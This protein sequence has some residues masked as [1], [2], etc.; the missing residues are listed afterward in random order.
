MIFKKEKTVADHLWSG[1]SLWTITLC[2]T[3]V[4]DNTELEQGCRTVLL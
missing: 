4:E 1:T 3:I 2:N